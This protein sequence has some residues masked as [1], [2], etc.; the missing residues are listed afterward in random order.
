MTAASHGTLATARRG[1]THFP[2][3]PLV[4][5]GATMKFDPLL[6]IGAARRLADF[7]YSSPDATFF[8]TIRAHHDSPF[9]DAHLAEAVIAALNWLRIHRGVR[10]YAYCLMPDHLHVLLR[11]GDDGKTLGAVVGAFK[12][13]TTQ[14]SW[15]LGHQ[16]P[17]W[18]GRFY[19]HVLRTSEDAS[20]IAA[21]ILH[22][23]ARSGLTDDANAYPYAGLPDA[24]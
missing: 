12:S 7:D 6:T 17:L 4:R 5:M 1:Q 18:Q 8:V 13:F 10:L 24:M 2:S 3:Q 20:G 14:Q 22:N 11:L 23:P 9:L 19:D 16:G 21:Y 15:H